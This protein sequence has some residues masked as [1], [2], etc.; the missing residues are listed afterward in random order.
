MTN[1][2]FL[3][4][5]LWILNLLNVIGTFLPQLGLR[6]LLAWEFWEAGFKK[7]NGQ[8]WFG[9]VKDNFPFPFHAIPVEV[10]WQMAM[11]FELIGSVALLIGLGTRFFTVS[12]MIL[13]IVAIA[14]VHWPIEWNTWT[15]L[16]NGGYD[17]CNR[18]GGNFKIPVMYLVMFLPLLFSGPG[19]LSLDHLIWLRHKN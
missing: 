7:F 15:E 8:N 19:K 3:N 6:V 1:N 18:D 5:S 14:S 4:L 10:S 13:T 11:W 12:L 9:S 16:F 2:L 17:V